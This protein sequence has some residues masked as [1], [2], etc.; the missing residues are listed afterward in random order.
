MFAGPDAHFNVD[1]NEGYISV[2]KY[3]F[4]LTGGWGSA[5]RIDLVDKE[6]SVVHHGTYSTCQCESQ[7][8]WYV[9]ASEF[10]IDTGTDERI[11]HNGVL[12]KQNKPQLASPW[13]SF[14]L[15]GARRSG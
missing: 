12:Y 14:P 2:P 6:R 5:R 7:P 3:R 13:L 10:D 15:S 9:N 1:A 11:A 8:A 4:H